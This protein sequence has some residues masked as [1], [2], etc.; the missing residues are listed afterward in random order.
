MENQTTGGANLGTC[1]ELSPEGKIHDIRKKIDANI[2]YALDLKNDKREDYQKFSREM[3]LAF[4]KLQEAK[5][6]AGKCLEAL[7]SELPEEFRDNA[8]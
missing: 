5:M 7:G 3:A 4:T 2:Q 1:T 6:W 8:V